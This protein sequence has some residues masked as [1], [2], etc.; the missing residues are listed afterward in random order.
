M[1]SVIKDWC[2]ESYPS[3]VI[4]ASGDS[5]TVSFSTNK[6]DNNYKG[7]NIEYWAEVDGK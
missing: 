2:G 7:F 3:A 5:A 6:G 4:K 1:Y